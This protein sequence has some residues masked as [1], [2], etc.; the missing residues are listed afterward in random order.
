MNRSLFA[1][2][3]IFALTLSCGGNK[4]A[5]GEVETDSD[6]IATEPET[7]DTLEQ[8]ISETPMPKAA[9]ELF[10]DFFFNFAAN[11]KLQLKRIKFP[12]AVTSSGGNACSIDRK[13]WKTEHFF[14]HQDYYTLI[15]NSRKQMET[16]KDTNVNHVVVEKISL[17][18]MSV[19]Q[20]VF[21]RIN[22]LWMMQTIH[23]TPLT[24]NP[25]SSFLH[26]Y[27]KFAGDSL[28]QVQ[29]V[30]DPVK[31]VGPDP[32]DDFGEMTGVL[33]PETWPAFAPE[34]PHKTIYN[35]IY[36]QPYRESQRRIFVL[37]GIANGLEMELSFK[38]VHGKWLLTEFNQ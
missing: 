31:F 36:G 2:I 7:I 10:D 33:T 3:A 20:Y 38:F 4:T 27:R 8:L 11:R 32:D 9:D 29:H 34:L 22:G 35:I 16:V 21:D 19:R 25:N 14:M 6:S 5:K 28:F 13:A 17:E 30:S 1:A 37:R 26:F 24:D 12:L 23:D 18:K 15:F